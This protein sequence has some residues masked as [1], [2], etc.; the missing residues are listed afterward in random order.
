MRVLIADDHEVTRRGLRDILADG[1]GEVDISEADNGESILAQV[2]GNSFDLILLDIMMP[3][4]NVIEVL[5]GI[6][7]HG[8]KVPVLVQIG[9]AHV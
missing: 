9:R 7:V 6:R 1:F 3:A 2:R 5:A 4:T 8:G